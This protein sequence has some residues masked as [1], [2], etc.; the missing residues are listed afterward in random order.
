MSSDLI[1]NTTDFFEE[2]PFHNTAQEY[3]TNNQNTQMHSNGHHP[4]YPHVHILDTYDELPFQGC[5]DQ[6]IILNCLSSKARF[7]ELLE[8]NGLKNIF[9][10]VFNYN[11]NLNCKYHNEISFQKVLKSHS[12]NALKVYHIN[13]RSLNKHKIILKSYLESLKCKFDIIFLT[14]TG[15]ATKHEIEHFFQDYE[16]LIDTPKPGKS[17]KGGAGIL[18]RRNTF[19][20]IEEIFENKNENLKD[21]CSCTQCKIENKWL[22]LKN[23]NTSYIVASVY[24]HPNGNTKHFVEGLGKHLSKMDKNSTCIIGGDLN[25]DLIKYKNSSVSL[26]IETLLEYNL[27]PCINIPTRI[28]DR[29]ATVIDHINV[30][31]PTNQINKKI[32]SGNLIT[33]ISDHLPNFLIIDTDISKTNDRPLIRL[34]NKKNIENFQKNISNE[35]MLLPYPR[36]NDPDQLLAEFTANLNKILNKYFPLIRISRKKFKD[37]VHITNEIKE[38]IKERNNLYDIFIIDRSDHN[39][40]KWLE[41]RNKTN[42]AIKNAEIKYYKDEIKQHGDNSQAM[43]KTLSHILCKNK[44]KSTGINSLVVGDRNLS[45]QSDIL[46]GLNSF[47]CNVGE[48]LANKFDNTNEDY[49]SFFNQP[50]N[51][52]IYLHKILQAELANQI[53]TLNSKKSSGHD[54]F[55]AK[56]LKISS[57]IVLEPLCYIFNLSMNTGSYPDELKI[58]KCIPIFKKGRKTDPSNYRPISI[59]SIINKLYEKL[60]YKR[61]YKYFTKFNILYDYQY[62]FR[63]KHSTTQ[64]LIEITDYLKNAID[65][66]KYI[67]GIFLDLTKAF[68]T[69]NHTILLDKL[70]NYGI[71][72]RA[73]KLLKS[74][75]TNRNQYVAIGN[76]QS[77]KQAIKCGVPQGSVLGPLL[78]L[79]YINDIVNSCNLG[80]IRIFADDTSNFVEGDNINEVIANAETSMNNLSKWFKANRLTLSSDKSSFMIFRSKKSK[81]NPLPSKIN[82]GPNSMNRQESVKYLGVTIDEHLTFNEHI[83]NVSNNLKKCFS[84]FYGV[85]DFINKDQIKTIYYSLIYS[86]IIYALPIYGLTSKENILTIQRMQNKLLK[87]LMKKNYRYSTNQLHNELEILKVEDLIDQEILTFVSNYKNCKLPNV[88]NNYFEFRGTRQIIRTR[89]IENSIIVPITNTNYGEQ[90]VKVKGSK[91]WNQLPSTLTNIINPKKFRKIWKNSKLPYADV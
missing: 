38:M 50:A 85:R 77:S 82:F 23:N 28:T 57:S 53:K 1:L 45:N 15:N 75:L 40:N 4:N 61:L 88:F 69:V 29:S 84:T 30:R 68:D 73:H 59:L 18:I 19:N 70:H 13:I 25:I 8:N 32:S 90:T 43:W 72:G 3:I 87:V 74:Y 55:T 83:E 78:F 21:S 20:E 79:V 67:C 42:Q 16:F 41:K 35:P 49:K 91:L 58:A 12:P 34:Y 56:F 64:A 76:I 6:E 62:G 47:F 44:K 26:Y 27:I 66:K 60:L 52:S 24:R 48:T 37:K 65:K 11:D 71:R 80:K 39:K 14:E 51:R 63:Q 17:N 36:S 86:K 81:L 9:S 31:L 2:L 10:N 46:E 89:N 22:K 54:G 7:L 33:D 5:N